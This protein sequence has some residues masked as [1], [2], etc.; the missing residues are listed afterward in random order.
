MHLIKLFATALI[1]LRPAVG[2]ADV[3]VDS[4]EDALLG[5]VV[6]ALLS[7]EITKQDL[8]S[9]KDATDSISESDTKILV[10]DSN[11]GDLAAAMEIGR[12]VRHHSFTVGVPESAQCLS[13]CVLVLAAGVERRPLGKVGI[14]RPYFATAPDGIL[15]GDTLEDMEETVSL[16]LDEMNVPERLAE[17]MFSIEPAEMRMLTRDEMAEYR[18]SSADYAYQENKTLDM[19][20]SLG[21]TREEYEAF[22]TDLNYSC[23]IFRGMSDEMITCI[24]KVARRHGI[25]EWR[26]G[27]Q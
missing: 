21:K 15:P 1:L 22:R 7:G 24:D 26:K 11:G 3:K 2:L 27:L 20:K 4:R 9:L 8:A 12:L 10:L 25:E 19:M 13:S 6:V 18:L 17:D 23:S 14:H 16:Y 5:S